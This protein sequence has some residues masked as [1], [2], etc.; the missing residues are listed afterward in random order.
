MDLIPAAPSPVP[1]PAKGSR[2]YCVLPVDLR[3]SAIRI[4]RAHDDGGGWFVAVGPGLTASAG[5][6]PRRI[7]DLGPTVAARLGVQL[8]GVDG[9]VMA[10]LAGPA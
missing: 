8:N 6:G 5:E 9:I 1:R 7:V 2:V 4:S 3:S 10:E